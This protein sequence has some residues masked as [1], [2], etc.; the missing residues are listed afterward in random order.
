MKVEEE[1]YMDELPI[2]LC[3]KVI[4]ETG[5]RNPTLVNCFNSRIV[6]SVPSSPLAF[7][8]C[9]TMTNG[10]GKIPLSVRVER[11]DTMEVIA[12][13]QGIARFRDPLYEVRL[14]QTMQDVVFPRYGEYQVSLFAGNEPIAQR[15]LRISP[16]MEEAE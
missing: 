8:I 15:K 1:P 9:A 11:L 6:P 5:T 4:I 3:E 10:K 16:P 14:F 2:V 13:R 12:S 7:M